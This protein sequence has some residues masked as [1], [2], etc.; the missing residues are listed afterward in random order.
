LR[1][2]RTPAIS[3]AL[4]REEVWTS[5][6]AKETFVND[7]VCPS[8]QLMSLFLE[9]SSELYIKYYFKLMSEY[10]N[11]SIPADVERYHS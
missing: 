3:S 5:V 10:G 1:A 9:C 11:Y 6:S 4:R 8:D 7:E 2:S